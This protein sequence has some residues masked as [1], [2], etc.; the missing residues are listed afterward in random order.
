MARVKKNLENL[1]ILNQILENKHLLFGSFDSV[2]ES[3]ENI[4]KELKNVKWKEILVFG[5]S[6]GFTWLL[7]KDYTYLR[8]QWWSNL[9]QNTLRKMDRKQPT[10]EG[11]GKEILLTEVEERVLDII[12]AESATVHGLGEQESA[13]GGVL[14]PMP[15]VVVEPAYADFVATD[16]SVDDSNPDEETAQP[17]ATPTP[18]NLANQQRPPKRSLPTKTPTSTPKKCSRTEKLQKQESRL[19]KLKELKLHMQISKLSLDLYHKK[20]EIYEKE[21]AWES[22]TR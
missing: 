4:T 8:D 17:P 9:K 10:G 22:R 1:E 11:G 12:G 14:A 19:G 16:Q 3:G 2:A 5:Q 7:G 18:S 13:V 6:Q 15:R 20:L 21:E